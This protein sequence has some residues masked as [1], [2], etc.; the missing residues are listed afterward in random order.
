MPPKN[1]GGKPSGPIRRQ[2]QQQQQQQRRR[3]QQLNQDPQNEDENH[4]PASDGD[5]SNKR[6]EAGQS[7]TRSPTAFTSL[8]VSAPMAPTSPT[9]ANDED[10]TT[11]N[12]VEKAPGDRRFS[13]AGFEL[14][15]PDVIAR[16]SWPNNS[17]VRSSSV[18]ARLSTLSEARRGTNDTLREALWE[19]TAVV[20]ARLHRIEYPKTGET[21]TFRDNAAASS[22]RFIKSS[23]SADGFG[24]GQ[25]N[26]D[27]YDGESYGSGESRELDAASLEEDAHDEH[28]I[29]AVAAKMGG[30]AIKASPPNAAFTATDA[31]YSN[32]QDAARALIEAHNTI[33][34]NRHIRVEQARVNRTLFIAKFSRSQSEQLVRETLSRYGPIEDL[35]LLQNYQTG[36]S[37]GCGFVKYCFREDAIKAFLG[38]RHTYKWVVKWASNLDRQPAD[39]DKHSIF[40]GQLNQNVVTP[41]LLREKFSRYGEIENLHLVNKSPSGPNAR[42]AFAFITYK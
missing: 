19:R 12:A 5:A 27:T 10:S 22:P 41:H 39:V 13:L 7:G 24:D 26:D 33:V 25:G 16:P 35:T 4:A 30:R 1:R 40:I 3:M 15:L 31:P 28:G 8:S 6:E 42:P 34:D 36:K 32:V 17:R 2:Q 23:S 20:A 37:K 38:L 18:D 29:R 9:Q 21:T 11:C 14:T